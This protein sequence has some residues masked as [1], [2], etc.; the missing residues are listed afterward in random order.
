M[1][2]YKFISVSRPYRHERSI[3]GARSKHLTNP[4]TDFICVAVLTVIVVV[5]HYIHN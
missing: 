1:T 5:A 4:V 3:Y 2:H